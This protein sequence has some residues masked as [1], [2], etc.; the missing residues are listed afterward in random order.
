MLDGFG[1]GRRVVRSASPADGWLRLHKG[2]LL[3]SIRI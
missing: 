3:A 1:L 2:N